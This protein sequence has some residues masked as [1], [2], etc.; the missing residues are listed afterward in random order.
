EV[1]NFLVFPRGCIALGYSTAAFGKARIA[2]DS[3]IAENLA[4]SR[5]DRLGCGWSECLGDALIALTVVVRA[6][7]EV[8]MRFPSI[9]ANAFARI[10][11]RACRFHEKR[12]ILCWKQQPASRNHRMCFQ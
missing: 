1:R 5:R 6:D 11:A 10:G 3:F 2:Y 4:R 12:R 9:P 8:R 7:I